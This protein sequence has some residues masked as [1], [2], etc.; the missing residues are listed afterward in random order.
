MAGR[1]LWGLAAYRVRLPVEAQG[2]S[3]FSIVEGR[4]TG[5]F[6]SPQGA[7]MDLDKVVTAT[8]AQA[9]LAEFARTGR[10]PGRL[11]GKL[12]RVRGYLRRDGTMP[13]DHPEQL[14]PLREA[15]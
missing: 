15:R 8:I 9:Q 5:A 11:R 4:V 2:A 10:D 6:G 14:E 7:E 13:L 1:G 3:G 12:V